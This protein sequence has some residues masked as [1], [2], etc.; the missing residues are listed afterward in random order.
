VALGGFVI[1]FL[2][3]LYYWHAFGRP[4]NIFAPTLGMVSSLANG[5]ARRWRT[6]GAEWIAGQIHVLI[7]ILLGVCCVLVVRWRRVT[8]TSVV[9]V[10]FGIAVTAF[11]Y[12]EQF[13]LG[14]DVLQ[15]FYYFSYLLPA[16][17]LMLAFLWQTLWEQTRLGAI[18]FIGLGLA[19][20]VV[21]LMAVS[22]GGWALPNLTAS[23]WLALG[24]VA[25][26]VVFL[27]TREWRWPAMQGTLP[28][29]AL[30]L[31][32]GWFAAGLTN[33]TG[34]MRTGSSAKNVEMDVYR[35]AL[36]FMQVVPKMADRRGVIKFWYNNRVGNSINSV[37]ST[38][39]WGFSKINANPPEDPGLPHLGELQLKLL[40]DPQMRYL[41]LLGETEDELSQGLAAL[42]REAIEF[43]TADFHVLASGD[44]RIFYQLVE[45]THGPNIPIR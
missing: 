11:Y 36:Q 26:V 14:S 45:L 44:Y 24:G 22:W 43:K 18:A 30:V 20:F 8:F 37:Q 42:T 41:G 4:I 39:L 32:G 40:R 34:L 5:G 7:P 28:L 23:H 16:I 19:A 31:I 35:V 21:P 10:S 6:E 15:L 33:Y 25:I 27:A 13:F 3:C 1:C 29:L 38:H 9:V 12:V 2:G 17:F